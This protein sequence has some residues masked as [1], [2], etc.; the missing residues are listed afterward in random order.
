MSHNPR[1]TLSNTTTSTGS[2]T[3]ER[4]DSSYDG[5]LVTSIVQS[6]TLNKNI[7]YT[8]NNDFNPTSMTYAGS[9]E[10][11]TYN[12]DNE[13]VSIGNYTITRQKKNRVIKVSDGTYT[14]ISKYNRYG[15]LKHQRDNVLRVRLF[16][17]KAGQIVRK[18]EKLKG[19]RKKVYRYSYDERG[20]LVKACRVGLP[21]HQGCE[22]YTYDNNGNRASAKVYG[23]TIAASYTLDDN[24][25]VYGDNSYLYDDDGYLQE[26]TTPQGS[27]TY[28]YGTLGELQQVTTPTQTITYKHN[29]NNQRVAKLVDGVIVEKYLWANLTTLLATYDA[30]DNLKQRFEYADQRMPISMTDA[31]GTMYYL[32]YD[33]VG[34]LKAISNTNGNIIKEMTYD[35]FGNML[36]DS[37]PSFTVPF[38]FAGGLYDADTKLTRFGYRDYDAY[39]GK[40][41]AKDPIGFSGGDS[42]LYGYVLG[43]PV[44]FVDPEG[45]FVVNPWTVGLAIAG[46]YLL[47]D[48]ISDSWDYFSD[49][50]DEINNPQELGTPAYCEQQQRARDKTIDYGKEMTH[51]VLSA[52]FPFAKPIQTIGGG[53]N[54]ATK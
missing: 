19:D 28:S 30:N 52:P 2:A 31:N 36:T 53:I 21:S 12:A 43:D 20:R 49:M 37:N 4:M 1:L 17:N 51:D 29:A 5:T 48:K 47:Y 38:G 3:D 7:S 18:V 46:G 6:G 14:H 13:A 23:T 33:Q 44:N 11:Y 42:N 25:V 35:T 54:E 40:W 50:I 39:T 24:L 16:R 41:T 27:T 32:H 26:K 15:E 9:T 8:C 45:L 34:T 22:T 10:N